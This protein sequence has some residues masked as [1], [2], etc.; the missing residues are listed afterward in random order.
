MPPPRLAPGGSI[1]VSVPN[2]T[3]GA[4]RLELLSGKFRY[5]D[6]GLLDRGHLRFF[7]REGVDELIREA[8]L[9]AETTLRVM[10][11]LDQTE[12]DIDL[13]NVPADL[14]RRWRA[15]SRH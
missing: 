9:R 5:R 12:F 8:G 6:S 4:V 3:H 2:V 11:R 10:R 14:D 13:T 7:D 15:T 1:L